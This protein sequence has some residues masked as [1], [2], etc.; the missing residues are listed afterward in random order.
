MLNGITIIK[1]SDI[2]HCRRFSSNACVSNTVAELG[3]AGS[4]F[5]GLPSDNF[6]IN[7]I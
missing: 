5:G 4:G 7:S 3:V 1:S 6:W 2:Y